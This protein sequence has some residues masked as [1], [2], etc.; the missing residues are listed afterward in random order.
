MTELPVG[1]VLAKVF[2]EFLAKVYIFEEVHS[3]YHVQRSDRWV[4][5]HADWVDL[6]L[7]DELLLQVLVAF[8]SH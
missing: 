2:G 3:R 4:W 8:S 6:H 5:Y 1:L 7:I